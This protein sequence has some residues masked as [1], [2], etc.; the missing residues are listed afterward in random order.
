M[1]AG[2]GRAGEGTARAPGGARKAGRRV[3]RGAEEGADPPF[4]WKGRAVA[5]IGL[6][7]IGGSWAAAVRDLVG[8]VHGCDPVPEARAGARARGLV[9]AA[10]GEPGPW[11][12]E[13]GLVILAVPPGVA[14]RV[15]AACL[16]WMKPGSILSDVCSIKA[17]VVAEVAPLL[18]GTGVSYVPGHPLAGRERSGL[19][20]AR[21]DLF[22]GA[23][24]VLCDPLPE[25]EG[26]QAWDQV[27]GLVR[28]MG[29][30]PLR[31][32]AVRHDRLVAA[33]SHLPYLVA[34]ALARVAAAV[35]A[36]GIPATA[37]ASS[38]FRDTTR[39]ALSPA[40]LWADILG[41]NPFL[42]EVGG[43]L[44]DQ[45][46]VLLEATRE[47]REAL[48]P[49]LE[50]GRAVREGL[51]RCAPDGTGLSAAAAVRTPGKEGPW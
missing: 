23:I 2:S 18:A 27:A 5:V 16:K 41:G 28:A 37:L 3:G 4:A 40:P 20:A 15:A 14:G 21:A 8:S 46:R 24:Y 25:G 36:G 30:R 51:D 47:G 42:E 34:V 49:L 19:E 9:D 39:V 33:S 45:L 7:L 17:R 38:G 13:C 10:W 44:L 50:E 32:D 12:A 1:A 22:Q 26:E 31:L 29:A 35:D 11:L 43:M 6:G 48:V